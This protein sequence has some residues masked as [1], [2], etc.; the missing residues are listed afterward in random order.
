ML[1]DVISKLVLNQLIGVLMQFR[2]NGRR[3]FRCTMFQ[4]ALNYPTAVR[5]CGQSV[6]LARER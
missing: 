2:Q 1:N 6:D 5:M 4:D 3:L